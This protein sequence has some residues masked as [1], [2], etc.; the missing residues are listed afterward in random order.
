M[1][2][3]KY[4]RTLLSPQGRDMSQTTRQG[5]RRMSLTG[6]VLSI[7]ALIFLAP[8][9]WLLIT[10]L[11]DPSE[12]AAFPVHWL[13]QHIQWANFRTAVTIID[14]Q[15]YA[16]NSVILA[17]IYTSLTTLT[18]ALVGFAFARLQGWGK[19]LLFAVMLATIMLPPILTAIPT[20][21][22]FSHL[23]LV[24]T[25]WPWVLWGLGTSPFFT[26][27]FRQF[28]A[29]LPRELEDAAIIDG[30]NY[31]QVFWRIFLP[32]SKPVVATV[33]I[34]SFTATWGDWFTPS[35]FLS[36]Q[37]TTLAVAVQSGYVDEHGQLLVNLVASGAILYILPVLLL[38]FFAQRYFVQ[39]IVTS[40][41]KG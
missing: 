33:A 41:L 4:R 40:G 13:P 37:N 12:L 3:L 38:F 26:F 1:K 9:A 21:I 24:D 30:C 2:T 32:L 36:D 22:L 27:L 28:F 11:K 14:Y 15:R 7:L 16:I 20:Y 31:L 8:F 39:G 35:L 23:G 17:T 19:Q 10:A 6:G 18:C 5:Q 34:L 25:Y 29:G